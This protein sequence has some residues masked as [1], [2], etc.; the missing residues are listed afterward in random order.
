MVSLGEKSLKNGHHQETSGASTQ[1]KNVVDLNF[2]GNKSRLASHYLYQSTRHLSEL[3]LYDLWPASR[4][5]KFSIKANPWVNS[6]KARTFANEVNSNFRFI[7]NAL[8]PIQMNGSSIGT[9]VNSASLKFDIKMNN[10]SS[11]GQ[12]AADNLANGSSKALGSMG[13]IPAVVSSENL[14][15]VGGVASNQTHSP[16]DNLTRHHNATLPSIKQSI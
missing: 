5:V 14:A 1:S 16:S 6:F 11:M 2:L 15:N 7:N 8:N 9:S 13:S 3:N 12:N 10:Y 4:M